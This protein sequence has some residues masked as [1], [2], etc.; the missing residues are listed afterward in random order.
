MTL[1]ISTTPAVIGLQRT[2]LT[3]SIRQPDADLQIENRLPKVRI[4]NTF[5][6]VKI[7]QTQP[8]SEAGLKPVLEWA[9]ESAQ[10]AR[11]AVGEYTASTVDQGNQMANVQT[12]A[13]VVADTADNNAFGKFIRDYNV[14]SMPKSKPKI[15]FVDGKAEITIEEGE[16]N[17]SVLPNAPEIEFR[18]GRV[19]VYLQQK[20]SIAIT[21]D[22]EV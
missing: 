16:S 15:D 5:T 21:F 19:D 14:E 22:K 18:R 17:I 13:D 20:N 7:D 1:R 6:Q 11:Q 8:F 2:P 12:Q 9:Y 4:N 3:M 10:I